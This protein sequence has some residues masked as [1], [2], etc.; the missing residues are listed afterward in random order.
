MKTFIYFLLTALFA[1]TPQ[2]PPVF[3]AEAEAAEMGMPQLDV[4]YVP[5][6]EEVVTEM[7]NLAGVN[8]NDVLYDLGSGDGRIVI[9]AAEQTGCRGVGID[10][11][12][13][14]VEEARENLRRAGVDGVEFRQGDLFQADISEASVVTIYLLQDVNIRLRPK[15]LR[16]LRPG[17]RVVSHAFDMGQWQPDA[18]RGVSG[19]SIFYWVVPANIS[20][21]WE[22]K[23]RAGEKGIH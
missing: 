4:P 5:T 22:W 14:R 2:A 1:L 16:D 17:S 20:G 23:N 8:R 9:Q 13:V 7:I 21:T 10:I 18:S 15:L 19:T 3:L 6:G 11:D 12:P